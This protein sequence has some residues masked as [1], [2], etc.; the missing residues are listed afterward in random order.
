MGL[1]HHDINIIKNRSSLKLKC[2]NPDLRHIM[3]QIEN[4]P[5]IS[6]KNEN[7]LS[8][9]ELEALKELKTR[10]A[11]VIKKADKGNV[12]IVLDN[13]FYRDK[14]VLQDHLLNTKAYNLTNSNAD[15]KVVNIIQDL[16][17]KHTCHTANEI[18]FIRT[19]NGN[20]VNPTY[21]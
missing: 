6:T 19:T 12:M 11:I 21:N 2:D 17:T 8:T 4:T 9:Q 5:R 7:N 16:T 3:Q 1:E 18:T 14:L 20:L 13:T 15:K 10:T